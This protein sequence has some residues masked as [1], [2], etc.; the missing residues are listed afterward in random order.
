VNT[1]GSPKGCVEQ[2]LAVADVL[3]HAVALLAQ[4]PTEH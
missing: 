2:F 4:T 1:P 3:A